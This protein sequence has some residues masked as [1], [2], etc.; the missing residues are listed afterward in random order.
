MNPNAAQTDSIK[1]KPPLRRGWTTGA[2]ATAALKSAFWGLVTGQTLDPVRITLPKGQQPSFTLAMEKKT[3]QLCSVGIIKDAGDDPD[4]THL[5]MIIVSVCASA[6]KGLKFIAGQGVGRV[7]QAGLPIAVGEA[8]ITPMPRA[9]MQDAFSEAQAEMSAQ[10]FKPPLGLEVT[11]SIPNGEALAQKTM[12]PRL[13]ILGGLSILG[14][15]GVVVPYSCSAWIHSI[16]R[17]VDVALAQGCQ[18]LLAST[19]ARSEEAAN[20]R[21]NLPQAALLDMGDFLGATLKYVK[22]KE[23][24]RLTLAGGIGKF[25]KLAQGAMDLH[26]G[27]SQVDCEALA[28]LAAKKGCEDEGIIASITSA[29]SAAQALASWPQLAQIIAKEAR[30]QAQLMIGESTKIDV[31]LF[32]R[33]ADQGRSNQPSQLIAQSLAD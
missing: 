32:S 1:E 33:Q 27:R 14:T 3:A 18:H 30:D 23:V 13:G 19:G 5:A 22:S 10:G 25:S 20:A 4:I 8:A 11:I 7:T 16:Y 6:H 28:A 15:T 21:L 2:C 9:M 26:S 31:M 12:N 24:E 29:N 17:G